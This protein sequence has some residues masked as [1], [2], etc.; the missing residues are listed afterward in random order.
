MA[1]AIKGDA[2]ILFEQQGNV[3][4]QLSDKVIDCAEYNALSLALIFSGLQAQGEYAEVVLLGS[5]RGSLYLPI[6]LPS[7]TPSATSNRFSVDSQIEIPVGPRYCKVRLTVAGTA[8][9]RVDV[10][11]QPYV[12]A[13]PQWT[14]P[15]ASRLGGAQQWHTVLNGT[16]VLHE[17][18]GTLYALQIQNYSGAVAYVHLYDRVA[19]NVIVGTTVPDYTIKVDADSFRDIV[20]PTVG[21]TFSTGMTAASTTTP[22]GAIGSAAGVT[23]HTAFAE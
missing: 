16:P 9:T 19:S 13:G 15:M 20:I 2:V 12:S 23:L 10:I 22:A 3:T 1:T 8:R 7:Y 21:I 14:T 4:G 18:I 5:S 17:G 6:P 11:A